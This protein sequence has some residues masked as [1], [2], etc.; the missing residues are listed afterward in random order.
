M[1]RLMIEIEW[2]ICTYLAGEGA[3][4]QQKTHI[5]GADVQKCLAVTV[6]AQSAGWEHT[7]GEPSEGYCWSCFWERR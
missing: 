7:D 4:A 6:E 5:L 3:G 1:H 2:S